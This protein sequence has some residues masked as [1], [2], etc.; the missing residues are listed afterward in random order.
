[1]AMKT[2]F[3]FSSE[4]A[5]TT[6]IVDVHK[7]GE[8]KAAEDYQCGEGAYDER[9]SRVGY[10]V[11]VR[12]RR[13]PRVAVGH[14]RVEHTLENAL[15]HLEAM[16]DET[17]R[18]GDSASE[19][20]EQRDA[21]YLR[22]EAQ[23]VARRVDEAQPVRKVRSSP[24][25]T[26]RPMINAPRVVKVMIPSPPSCIRT[27]TTTSPNAVKVCRK[28]TVER[29]V[30]LT[31]LTETNTASSHEMP[32]CVETGSFSISAPSAIR[33]A[34]LPTTV[35]GAV[36]LKEY[37]RA[38]ASPGPSR[39]RTPRAIAFAGHR[40]YLLLPF[41]TVSDAVRSIPCASSATPYSTLR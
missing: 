38:R 34:K 2:S 1:M 28:S 41:G 16:P 21:R 3:E 25:P 33:A 5:C 6:V 35:R 31:A 13:E 22:Y 36:T 19:L 40:L 20:H 7:H 30:T 29:P 15:P 8:T 23:G 39:P 24:K 18:Q 12:E 17:D 26:R 32:S 27:M 37:L 11:S 14:D 9:I 10:E 4:V